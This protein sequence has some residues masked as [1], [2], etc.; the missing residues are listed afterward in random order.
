[1]KTGCYASLLMISS[2]GNLFAQDYDFEMYYPCDSLKVGYGI[3]AGIKLLNYSGNEGI[4]FIVKSNDPIQWGFQPDTLFGSDYS[5]LSLKTADDYFT[6]ET[7]LEIIG[8]HQNDSLKK[9]LRIKI[10]GENEQAKFTMEKKYLSQALAYIENSYPA[11]RDEINEIDTSSM[12]CY[13]PF[14][15]FDIVNHS[16]L[17]SN[18]W[19]INIQQHVMVPPYD[20]KKIFLWNETESL[21]LGVQIDTHGG[22]S[23]IPCQLHYYFQRIHYMP[24][25]INLTGSS[26]PEDN[27]INHLVG[28]LSTVDNFD[29]LSYH[30]R[31]VNVDAPFIISNGNELR[32]NAV[33]NFEEDSIHLLDILSENDFGYGIVHPFIISVI[34]KSNPSGII[35]G[36]VGPE[37]IYIREGNIHFNGWY[38]RIEVYDLSG[39]MIRARTKA[40]SI[41]LNG[42]DSQ[43]VIVRLLDL[44][45]SRLLKVFFKK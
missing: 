22:C 29:T 44:N 3:E 13:R 27:Q 17:L 33:L 14:P 34:Q 35:E 39:R 26:I 21:C 41:N 19:R 15:A 42:L 38:D 4:R 31:I 30:Y 9:V 32:A 10:F 23:F 1:M 20:W 37:Y 45:A 24:L 12:F 7:D 43:V 8:I 11:F 5:I 2:L 25:D 36:K 18:H 16:V 40:S 28:L 6:G